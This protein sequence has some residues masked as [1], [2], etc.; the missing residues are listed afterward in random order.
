MLKTTMHILLKDVNFMY[1]PL[2][3]EIRIL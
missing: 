3:M 1:F 2:R